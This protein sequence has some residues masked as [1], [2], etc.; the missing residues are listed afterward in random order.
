MG[1]EFKPFPTP[2]GVL[3]TNRGAV[4]AGPFE[5]VTAARAW[6]A[7]R[8]SIPETGPATVAIGIAATLAAGIAIAGAAFAVAANL[9]AIAGGLILLG[10]AAFIAGR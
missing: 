5:S 8:V 9:P 7:G 4:V 2:F 1:P 10:V 6:I 3:V